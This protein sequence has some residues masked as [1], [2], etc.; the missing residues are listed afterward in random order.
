MAL[1][2]DL[3][4]F[5][6]AVLAPGVLVTRL[7]LGKGADPIAIWAGGATLGLF[8]VPLLTYAT[9]VACRTHVSALLVA[10]VGG[11]LGLPPACVLWRR[12]RAPTP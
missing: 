11:A 7:A 1:A 8:L 9:A 2:F 5:A 6:L 10:A 12:A 3:L 4:I